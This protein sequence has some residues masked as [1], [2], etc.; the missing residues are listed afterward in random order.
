MIG[1]SMDASPMLELKDRM[2]WAAAV[3]AA[4]RETSRRIN[5]IACSWALLNS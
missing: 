3:A 4:V 5:W 2:V 1:I